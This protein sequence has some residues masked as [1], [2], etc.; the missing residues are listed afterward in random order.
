ML[1]HR[2][3]LVAC[4][5][6]FFALTVAVSGAAANSGD[7]ADLSSAATA[8]KAA[9]TSAGN[10]PTPPGL[11]FLTEDLEDKVRS[12][13]ESFQ[14]ETEVTKMMKLIIN[15]LYKTKEI[16]LRELISNASDA[17]DKIRFRALTDKKALGDTPDLKITLVADKERNT[18]T[19]TDSGVGMTF[20]ELKANLG[21]IA[22]SGT[23]EFLATVES[24][25]N[26]TNLIGQ[27]GVGFY[28]SFLVADRVTVVT[29]NNEDK[30]W[31][32]ES[33]SES[34]FRIIEDPRGNTL[35][36]GTQIVLHLK[37]DARE[38]LEENRLRELVHRHSEFVSFPIYLWATKT[39]TEEVPIEAEEEEQT[40]PADEES[41]DI[42]DITDKAEKDAA[43]KTK[44]VTKT[45]T[46]WELTNQQK[47]IWTRRAKDITEREYNEFYISFTK[48]YQD[49]LTYNHFR[50][51]GEVEFNSILYIP[52]K[53]S[54]SFLQPGDDW[55]KNIRLFVRRVFITDDL[56]GFL[57]RW[58]SFLKGLVDSDDL[59]LNVSRETLQQHSIIKVIKKRVVAKAIDMLRALAGKDEKK[60][61]E[62]W[63][64]YGAAIKL[65]VIEDQA[66][67]KK[68]VKLLRFRSS[69]GGGG[70]SG[71]F[72][73][74]DEYV[75]RMRKAQPQIYFMSGENIET[76]GTSPFVEKLIAR[77][78][79]VL[80][81]G[82][83]IDEYLV[84][85]L[86]EHDGKRLQHVGK[87]GVKY[88]DEDEAAKTA[89]AEAETKFEPLRDYL[90]T[91]LG[92][93]VDTVRVSYQLTTSPCA[94]LAGEHGVSGAMERMLQQQ[95]AGNKDDFRA[96]MYLQ[97]KKVFEINPDHP[98]ILGM[99]E[100]VKAGKQELL[101]DSVY[102]LFEATSIASGFSV[103]N[104]SDFAKKVEVVVRERLGV[105]AK[106][107]ATVNV[108]PAPDVEKRSKKSET[109]EEEEKENVVEGEGEGE[110][111]IDGH[112]EL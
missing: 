106:A 76:M 91:R 77:G 14:F 54:P 10:L 64:Q 31:I 56:A 87:S 12:A 24:Q 48:D 38:Y 17:L 97:Q 33:T 111:E 13:G 59:P 99:L 55:S 2:Q 58:L 96:K 82:D 102:V 90:R 62:F 104:A 109:E 7:A 15:S 74:L 68:L 60:Y 95:V 41:E 67:K 23:A 28:S 107:E 51:E 78:Y 69:H 6:F 46:D 29:K 73:S 27:F 75:L 47:P 19:I 49:P 89:L 43:P 1:L 39:E 34:N 45:V 79:E 30:Q 36:R 4:F 100:K 80:Y 98:L 66:N 32:W 26:N 5:A 42:E 57:P 63:E 40:T 110:D 92:E 3:L 11:S 105:D 93:W 86:V 101:D 83:A 50:A 108:V 103:R 65:G 18:L 88:G 84:N 71:L 35:G 70:K 81:F 8:A 94:V 53:P 61:L 72:T 85:V 44:T 9:S 112:D 37:P 20:K 52:K 21:T 16:F 22:K 25:K